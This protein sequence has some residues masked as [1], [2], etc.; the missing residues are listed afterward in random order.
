MEI[1]ILTSADMKLSVNKKNKQERNR[2]R[3]RNSA[4]ETLTQCVLGI[5]I[6]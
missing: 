5:K 2:K 1:L 4:F 3:S 6:I